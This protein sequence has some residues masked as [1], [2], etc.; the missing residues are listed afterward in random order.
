MQDSGPNNLNHVHIDLL[1]SHSAEVLTPNKKLEENLTLNLEY[2]SLAIRKAGYDIKMLTDKL[3]HK[4]FE[5]R[6]VEEW[7]FIVPRADLEDDK[8]ATT[9]SNILTS[10]Y[11]PMN[12]FQKM[13]AIYTPW[14]NT[15]N[16]NKFHKEVMNHVLDVHFRQKQDEGK[17]IYR[18][19]YFD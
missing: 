9:L 14:Y 1:L 12:E 6:P 10:V 2:P 3:I 11:E 17:F 19:R 4:T 13:H 7:G 18:N 15:E 16:V 5:L 8:L